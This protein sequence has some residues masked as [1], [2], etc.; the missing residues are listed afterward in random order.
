MADASTVA[1]CSL[2]QW[3]L[4]FDGNRDR[5]VESIREACA[6]GCTLRIGPELEIPGYGCYDHFLEGD[7]ELHSWQ[8]LV[9]ILQSGV[10]SGILCDVG[11]P[12]T[13]KSVLYNCRVA[14]LDGRIVHVRPKMWLA[15][16]GNYRE[17]R[18]FTP[19]TK[20]RQWEDH[21][22]PRIIREVTNQVSIRGS[23]S[24]SSSCPGQSSL[25]RLRSEPTR[26]LYWCRAV[27]GTVHPCKVRFTGVS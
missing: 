22:L 11:M 18:Y 1:S 13:H 27:R 20:H 17:L 7:T 25:R 15:N 6:A 16:D 21:Y 19:W 5:I 4:D 10:T 8:V 3:A 26:Y 9:E 14:I 12:I 23:S 2:N 24:L